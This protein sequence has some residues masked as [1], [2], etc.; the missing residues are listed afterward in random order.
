VERIYERT[1]EPTEAA[2]CVLAEKLGGKAN[3]SGKALLPST[4]T[5]AHVDAWRMN[6]L[7]K[8]TLEFN[9]DKKS[10]LRAWNTPI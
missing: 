8:A 10:E 5:S 2:L 4:L 1:G 7:R 3:N 9:R 6:N